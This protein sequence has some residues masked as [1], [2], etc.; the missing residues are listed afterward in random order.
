MDNEGRIYRD[1]RKHLDKLPTGFLTM[2][3]APDI[4]NHPMAGQG[5]LKTQYLSV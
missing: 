3:S 2:E 5:E 1:L 4:R